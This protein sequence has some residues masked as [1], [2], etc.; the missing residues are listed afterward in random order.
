[1]NGEKVKRI[2]ENYEQMNAMN[3]IN[4]GVMNVI[5]MCFS[6]HQIIDL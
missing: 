2:A 5:L 1:M 3:A 4:D 6:K